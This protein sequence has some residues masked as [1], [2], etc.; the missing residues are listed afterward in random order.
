[1]KNPDGPLINLRENRNKFK[2]EYEDIKSPKIFNAAADCGSG[3]SIVPVPFNKFP[4]DVGTAV[5]KILETVTH[6]EN[7]NTFR[8]A[9][10]LT[11]EQ[12]SIDESSPPEGVVSKIV[13]TFSKQNL[14][15][16]SNKNN[17]LILTI[18][19]SCVNKWLNPSQKYIGIELSATKGWGAVLSCYIR[20][21]PQKTLKCG[22]RLELILNHIMSLYIFAFEEAYPSPTQ[23][24]SF[25]RPKD[26]FGRM[27]DWM[28]QH[29]MVPDMCVM[30]LAQ[31]FNISLREVHRQFA[32]NLEEKTFLESLR[33]MRMTAAI[34]MLKDD[35]F[36]TLTIA[37]IGRRS[38]FDDPIYFCKVFKKITGCAPGSF[39]KAHK[40]IVSIY[41]KQ[42]VLAKSK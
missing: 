3:I 20:N 40:K 6:N 34:R 5:L 35:H 7:K 17:L 25:R 24:H 33:T 23:E 38:G 32:S 37:E 18:P 2:G 8:Y 42:C 21:V 4:L 11:E 13:L 1:M 39:S 12:E 30:R 19:D 28:E 16:D 15:C 27:Y 36:S 22:N 29:Y 14:L 10:Q 9:L 41:D 31:N 26:L